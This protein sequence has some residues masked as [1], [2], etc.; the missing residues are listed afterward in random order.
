MT[1]TI[2]FLAITAILVGGSL[3]PNI[4]QAHASTIVQFN[5]QATFLASTG[6]TCATCPMPPLGAFGSGVPVVVNTLTFA[7]VAPST[8]LYFGA[9]DFVVQ[10]WTSVIPGH[11]IAISSS[12][13]LDVSLAVPVSSF[14][15]QFYEP[16]CNNRNQGN[17][18]PI[19]SLGLV[20][21]GTDVNIG[22]E[23]DS[24]FTVTLKNGATTVST[25]QFNAPDDVL[26][27]VGVQSDMVFDKVEIRETIGGIDDENF[28]EF[29][30]GTT[31]SNQDPDCSGAIPNQASLFPPNHKMSDITISGVTDADGDTV[32]LTIDGITQDEPTNGLGDGDTSPDGNG[33]GTDTAQIRAERSGTGD[34]RV[35]EISFTA[36]DGNGGMCTG[37]V[38][39]DVPHDKKSTAVNSGQNFD[40]TQ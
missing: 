23:V 14:G 16:T 24:T 6:A 22:E 2:L 32:T 28:G 5:D 29:Y 13:N 27:F 17:D 9:L 4:Q 8:T 11:D 36:D 15:F 26:T 31:T 37:S 30:T 33:L 21:V 35:Y 1:K 7:S 10:D 12:E 20:D 34:G 40:S 3:T 18:C 19:G 25:F 39:V 38:S